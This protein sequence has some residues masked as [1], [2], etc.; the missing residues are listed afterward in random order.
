MIKGKQLLCIVKLTNL[1]VLILYN[2]QS[3]PFQ[4]FGIVLSAEVVIV[5]SGVEDASTAVSQHALG[6]YYGH[7]LKFFLMNKA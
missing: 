1:L 4:H 2:L 7:I 6:D 5:Y 3:L